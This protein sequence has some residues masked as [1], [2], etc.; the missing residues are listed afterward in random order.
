[1]IP[2]GIRFS[3]PYGGLGYEI[4]RGR[5]ITILSPEKKTSDLERLPLYGFAIAAA[6]QQKG[7]FVLHASAVEISGKAVAVAGGK[8]QGKS[9]L[10]AHLVARGHRLISDDVTAIVFQPGLAAVVPGIPCIKL[11]PD[12]LQAQG[13]NPEDYPR[14]YQDTG[15]RNWFVTE[16]FCPVGRALDTIFMLDHGDGLCLQEMTSA[17]KLLWLAGCGYFAKFQNA[18]PK[19]VTKAI[20]EDCAALV[21][22]T[23]IVKLNRPGDLALLG[24]TSRL[25]EGFV[26]G[27][28]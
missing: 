25:V 5:D 16:S 13:E 3:C 2:G 10:V 1:M 20:F 22:R 23:K 8:T 4:V 7:F 18:F 6:L 9:T 17:E 24:D 11:W 26:A 21:G 15:K 19:D 12:A 28:L 27:T 14:L